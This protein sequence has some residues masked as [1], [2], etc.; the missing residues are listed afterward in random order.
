MQPSLYSLSID[1]YYFFITYLLSVLLFHYKT[2][3]KCDSAYLVCVEHSL[4]KSKCNGLAESTCTERTLD[5][6]AGLCLEL[7]LD[8]HL[9][10]PINNFC[11]RVGDVTSFSDLSLTIYPYP[12]CFTNGHQKM[13]LLQYSA[14]SFA[15]HQ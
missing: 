12:L 4:F 14:Y 6:Y 5:Q 10:A 11:G 15:S 2:K 3:Q 8:P 13:Y 1:Y 7:Q 9:L